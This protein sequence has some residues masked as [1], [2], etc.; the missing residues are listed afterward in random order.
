VGEAERYTFDKP[1]D[2]LSTSEWGQK[3]IEQLA[4]FIKL[5]PKALLRR[6]LNEF[7]ELLTTK[8]E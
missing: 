1:V 5:I 3:A 2:R 8:E 4:T 7:Y 6:K